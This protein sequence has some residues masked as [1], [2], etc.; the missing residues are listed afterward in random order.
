MSAT[1]GYGY[2]DRQVDSQIDWS[3]VASGFTDTLQAEIAGRQ[4]KKDEL[5][6]AAREMQERLANAPSGTYTEANEFAA[7]FAVS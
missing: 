1:E 4:A 2:V 6:K 5:D 3:A 7:Q